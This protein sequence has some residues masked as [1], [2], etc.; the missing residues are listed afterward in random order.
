MKKHIISFLLFV[1]V[2]QFSSFAQSSSHSYY[3]SVEGLKGGETL[4]TALHNLLKNHVRISYGSGADAT[5]GAFYTTDV[6]LGTT[7]QVADMYSPE[8][9]YFGSK[10][11]SVDGMNIEHSVPKSWWGG[12]QNNAYYDLHHLNPSDQ[13]ANSRK[14]NYP[15]AELSSVSWTN[16]I[17]SVGKAVIAGEN[18]NAYEPA[19]QYKGDFA[20]TYMYMFT[21]YQ[22]L[23]WEYTW[24]VYENSAY[25]TMKPWAVELLLKWHKQDP[26][27]EKEI[28]RNDSVYAIQGNR[29]PY[30]DYPRLADF[31]W[32]DSVNFLFKRYGD[33]EDGSGNQT[34]SG[35]SGGNDGDDGNGSDG[36]DS[37]N[38]GNED[39]KLSSDKYVLIEDVANLTVGDTIIIVYESKAMSTNQKSNNRG[40]TSVETVN[41]TIVTLSDDVQKIALEHGEVNGTFA[42]NV[43]NSYLY[44]ASSKNNYLRTQ[45][46]KDANA[47][48]K[49]EIDNEAEANIVAQ[50]DKSRNILQYNTSADLFSCYKSGQQP[51]KIY[52][53]AAENTTG[54]ISV[55]DSKKL[56]NIYDLFGRCIRQN[57]DADRA[58][59][60]LPAGLYIIDK[61]KVYIK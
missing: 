9:R 55:S 16:G 17:S 10:G 57:I 59:E 56:V 24:M 32:G 45:N 25:P 22:N 61:K 54:T 15:L 7:N 1:L 3:S 35:E 13:T 4:K 27:S 11:S 40:T 34:G 42:F 53:K 48:W 18:Q 58:T 29:N 19:D 31:V 33:V 26:V 21:C 51:V 38:T 2:V 50:G 14:S 44:A 46:E 12:G 41:D 6:V 49:I 37:G 47:S 30:V 39:S 43:G 60:N 8:I 28:A 5:W 23:T 20:R 52:A 36:G